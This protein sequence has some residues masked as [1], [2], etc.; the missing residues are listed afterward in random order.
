MTD[1]L[2]DGDDEILDRAV[3]SETSPHARAALLDLDYR[4]LRGTTD[5]LRFAVNAATWVST[6]AA[7]FLLYGRG[8]RSTSDPLLWAGLML[9]GVVGAVAIFAV[10]R[11]LGNRVLFAWAAK[12]PLDTRILIL[13]AVNTVVGTLAYAPVIALADHRPEILYGLLLSVLPI[14]SASTMQ[15]QRVAQVIESGSPGIVPWARN[16]LGEP[17]WK[18]VVGGRIRWI[19]LG[20]VAGGV[21]EIALVL[22]LSAE[23]RAVLVL[24]VANVM[25]AYAVHAC[26]ERSRPTIFAA[27]VTGYAIALA[28]IAW[29]VWG[30]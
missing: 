21:Q 22:I 5:R 1:A 23:P 9:L 11:W 3:R 7:V 4:V 28:G 25:F 26:Y 10:Q 29:A 13:V 6:F 19:V 8:A 30:S 12:L 16:L 15:T 14:A 27:V 17:A 18:T 20:F 2:R 24:L